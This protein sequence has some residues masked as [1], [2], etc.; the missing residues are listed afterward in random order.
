[1]TISIRK[2]GETIPRSRG[3]TFSRFETKTSL[4]TTG[5]DRVSHP[6]PPLTRDGSSQ[7]QIASLPSSLRNLHFFYDCRLVRGI[8]FRVMLATS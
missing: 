7:T 6:A 3:E 1:M 4:R 8:C 5:G 2:I